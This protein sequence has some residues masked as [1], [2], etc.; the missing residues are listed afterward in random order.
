MWDSIWG[1]IKRGI[2]SLLIYTQQWKYFTSSYLRVELSRC[3]TFE[4]EMTE[5]KVWKRQG[6]DL[7]SGAAFF[8]SGLQLRGSE[9]E[10]KNNGI[11]WKSATKAFVSP[12]LLQ[13]TRIPER[14]TCQSRSPK[15]R[16]SDGERK[17][18]KL[19]ERSSAKEG[20]KEHWEG[21]GDGKRRK[22][23]GRLGS[24]STSVQCRLLIMGLRLMAGRQLFS[25]NSWN[26]V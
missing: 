20:R 16:G 2:E 10:R 19:W 23:E 26:V 25:W 3:L 5:R 17:Y 21:G 22:G 13:F 12:L 18:H 14:S 11:E 1:E 24:S 7:H 6:P 15:F 8:P 4:P 9:K